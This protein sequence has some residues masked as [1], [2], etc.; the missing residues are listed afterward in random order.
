MSAFGMKKLFLTLV[1]F[2][3]VV[4]PAALAD[5]FYLENAT[6]AGVPESDLTT[7]TELIRNEIEATN[8]NKIV[9]DA[10]ASLSLRPKILRL[11]QAY[12]I[13]LEKLQ[14]G[15]VVFSTQLKADHIEEIDKVT[16]RL[17]EALLS[18]KNAQEDSRVGEITHQESHD[19]TQRKPSRHI[20]YLGFG[21]SLFGAMNT[22]NVGY[23]F[24]AGFGWDV[25]DAII[26]IQGD[27]SICGPAYFL[28]VGIEGMFFLSSQSIAPYLSADFGF[29][30]TQSE[31]SYMIG[32]QTI[33]GFDVGGGGG[34][35]L[36][37]TSNISIDVGLRVNV[38]L[39]TNNLGNP[40]AGTL[41]LGLYF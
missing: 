31:S 9:T 19:G 28:N 24:G 15:K 26:K 6:G 33:A 22:S 7:T 36:L 20:S 2:F 4:S 12:I 40:V 21:G 8:S 34:V 14:D 35:L 16:K 17:V 18:G 41:R 39:S 1:L 37:R 25:N 23:A 3:A 27:F 29:G 38:L 10:K 32:G 5:D 11:G 30:L 13:Q